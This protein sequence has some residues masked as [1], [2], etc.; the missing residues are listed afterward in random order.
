MAS[1]P[2]FFEL[3][4]STLSIIG[5]ANVFFGFLVVSV[6]SLSPIAAVPIVTSIACAFANGL[7]YHAFYLTSLP[8]TNR[9]VASGFA[10]IFWLVSNLFCSSF[11][12]DRVDSLRGT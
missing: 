4:W 3:S 10:D 2:V 7:C 5:A 11:F 12:Q 8:V 6:T 9:A 1:D